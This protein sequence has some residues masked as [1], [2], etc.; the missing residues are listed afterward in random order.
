MTSNTLPRCCII[1]AGMSGIVTAKALA[2][3]GIPFD[4]F[5]MSD[6]IG[7]VWAFEN[8][9]GRSAAY[10]SLHIDTSKGQLEFPDF[11]MPADTPLLSPPHAGSGVPAILCKALRAG[12]QGFSQDRG[13]LCAA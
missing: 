10:R 5:E 11:P 4:W 6:R 9:N 13:R 3:R 1:G 12:R 7:G 8:P 2:D